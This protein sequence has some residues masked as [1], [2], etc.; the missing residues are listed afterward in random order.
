MNLRDHVSPDSLS[1]GFSAAN[2]DEVLRHVAS[3]AL[4]S[5]ACTATEEAV[6]HALVQRERMGSTGFENGIAIP[7]ARLEGCTDFV[8]GVVTLPGGVDFRAADGQPTR[9]VVFILGPPERPGDHVKLLSAVSRALSNRTVRDG[10]LSAADATAAIDLL[11]RHTPAAEGQPGQGGSLVTVFVQ[12]EKAFL[13]ILQAV[14]SE[15]SCIAVLNASDASEYLHA[16]PLYAVLW[17]DEPMPFNRVI[18]ASVERRC[19]PDLTAEIRRIAED[20]ESETGVLV[21]VQDLAYC[22]GSL[23]AIPG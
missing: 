17:N 16:L 18:V 14:S 22:F 10:L 7:H 12:I 11:D 8:V 20:L 1:L 4:R 6:Y 9:L 21:T 3:L 19:V 23:K 2:R 13:D 15:T 5:P